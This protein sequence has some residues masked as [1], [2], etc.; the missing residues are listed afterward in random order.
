MKWIMLSVCLIMIIAMH[1]SI[2]SS[3]KK[4]FLILGVK[5]PKENQEDEEIIE[6]VTNFKYECRILFIVYLLL[7]FVSI[8]VAKYISTYILC[9]DLLNLGY[10]RIYDLF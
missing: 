4:G 6:N 7:A 2:I 5:I 3:V 9:V 10:R 8:A 1:L